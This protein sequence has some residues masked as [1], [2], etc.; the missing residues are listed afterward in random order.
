MN[1][2]RSLETFEEI[3]VVVQGP[4][5]TLNGRKQEEK[6]TRRCLLSVREWLPGARIILSTWP[7][8]NLNDLNYDELVVSEDPGPNIRNFHADGSPQKYN[9]NRQIVSTLAGLKRVTTPYALKLRSDNYLTN[10]HFVDLQSKYPKRSDKQAIF[11]ERVVVSNVFTRKYAKG[12]RVAHHLSDFFY[13]GL[14]ADLLKIWDLELLP[15][16]DQIEASQI[17][18]KSCGY[19]ID[20]T[21]MF[22]IKALKKFD[23]S[24][25]LTGLLDGNKAQH[26]KS[27][28]YYANNLIIGAREDIG[29][30]LEQKF[31]GEAR[32]ARLQ[33]RCAQWQ[34]FEWEDLYK[35]HC[36]PTFISG[37]TPKER[38]VY[39]FA[40]LFYVL[41]S[42][43][44]TR[45]KLAVKC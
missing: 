18:Q 31:S 26:R 21:Q 22:W 35:R 3:T 12:F 43:I 41:P 15:N 17:N 24:V 10:N 6:I 38:W 32:I 39:T 34:L 7:S 9:N 11:Q 42:F 16:I 44:K 19:P 4:V 30:G 8:Q 14:T 36:D 23:T 45:L 27:D 1:K 28:L 33:G 29:L 37:I 40:R 5:Q 25:D 20:C 13:F 2:D